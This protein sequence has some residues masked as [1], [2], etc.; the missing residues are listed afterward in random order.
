MKANVSVES[1]NVGVEP[2]EMSS[3]VKYLGV[4]LENTLNIKMSASGK[5]KSI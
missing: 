3:A 4:W 2:G 5:L 1:I